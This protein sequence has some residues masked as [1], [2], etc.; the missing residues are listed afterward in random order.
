MSVYVNLRSTECKDIYSK[1]HG[2][3]FKIE[4]NEPLRLQGPWEVALAEMT[5]HA[6]AFPNLPPEHSTAQVTLQEQLQVYDTRDKVFRITTWVWYEK[7]GYTLTALTFL[8][9]TRF[10]A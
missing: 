3:N 6:Q 1:N 9:K 10:P 7:N 2:G 5:Y 4:L 8:K